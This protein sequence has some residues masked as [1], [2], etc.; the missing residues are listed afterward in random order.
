MITKIYGPP[1][2]G[3]TEKLI[4][5]AMAYIRIGT[6]LNQIGYFAFTRK[7]AN[8]AKDRML[9]KNPQY[10]KKDLPY[11]RTFHSLAFQKLSLD[12]SKV[13]Q[14]YHYADL[15]RILSIR[16]N[17]RKDVDASPYLTCDNEYFQII[18]KAKEKCISV[19][20]E[21]CSGEYSSSVRW[22][23][24]EHIEANY[25]EYKKKNT[26]LNYSDMINQFI[27]KP[28]L[29]PR[30]KVMFVDEAQDLSPLQWKMYDLLKSNSDDVYLAGDDDQ[31]I[32]TWAGADVKRF[33]EEPA[34]ERVLSR[35]RRIPKKVQELSSIVISRIRGLRATKH[36]KARDEEGKVEKI[37]SLDNL[38]LLSNKW[39]IL[40]RT[41][42]RAN[43]ICKILK[44]KGIYFETKKGKSYNV[45][46]YKA[47]LTHMQYVNDEEIS[48]IPMKDL[49]DFVDEED[50]QDKSLKWYEVFSKGNILE[51]NYIR[52]MLS[53]KEKLNQEPRI[54]VSTIHAAKGGEADN[55]VLVLDNANKIRQAVM[56]SITKSD[57]E[58]RVWYVGTTRA[59]RNI[60]ILQ[61]KIERKGYQL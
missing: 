17:V 55:V 8:T 10:K 48:E 30:F 4:R 19:W 59:K 25:N 14:D 29:C 13:M 5:R 18:L 46:L 31:A 21:Y 1:G 36:Y 16:V 34:K 54:K 37:N 39:L 45:K 50:L 57:E 43:E 3:K 52:L 2:T 9:E 40:T 22:G 47:I 35:S 41:L 33:I 60:Y 32:Y 58:H 24:L 20:D 7:A 53:N 6:P 28:H 56:R 44:D 51:R 61:A 49:L 23:L 15:G 26:L 42:N 38:D 27:D 12:E 11:F